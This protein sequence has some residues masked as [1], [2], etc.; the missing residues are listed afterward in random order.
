MI[1]IKVTCFWDDDE[2]IFHY[3]RKIAGNT[4]VW[5]DIE[6]VMHDNYDKL[7]ILTRP[8]DDTSIYDER[9]AITILT[10][11]PES[12][13]IKEHRTGK[14]VD[15]YLPLPQLLENDYKR[16]FLNKIK[17]KEVLSIVTS[18]MCILDGHVR[19]LNFIQFLDSMVEEG[20]TV[21]GRPI[22]GHFFNTIQSYRGRLISKYDGLLD[23]MYHFACENSFIEDYFTEK[24]T[25]ALFA[26]CL[27][28]YDGC[29]NINQ[30]IDSRS[31]LQIDVRKP[32]SSLEKIE[33]AIC[34]NQWKRSIKFIREQKLRL[35]TVLNPVNIIWLAVMEKDVKKECSL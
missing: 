20:L 13:N 12:P 35:K 22:N 1:K 3:L 27:C 5:K 29:P 24:I 26:E 9:N 4:C 23:Y 19:R 7:I 15:F 32:Y 21:W 34:D 11:P 6:F 30:Y 31:F 28:F 16:V 2:G 14:I 10:E 8:N 33:K 17:K 25:D 18:E